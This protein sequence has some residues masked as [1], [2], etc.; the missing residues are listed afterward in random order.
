MYVRRRGLTPPI[1]GMLAQAAESRHL[2]DDAALVDLANHLVETA[3]GTTARHHV[4]IL[5]IISACRTEDYFGLYSKLWLQSK[6]DTA[7]ARLDTIRLT[8]QTWVAHERLGRVIGAFVPIFLR[9]VE[10]PEY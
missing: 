6:Y 4:N 10:W 5:R 7:S 8:R 9:T 2:V 1:S 3:V